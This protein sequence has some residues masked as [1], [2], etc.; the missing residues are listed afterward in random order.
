MCRHK[1]TETMA[2]RRMQS[3][4]LP[5][6]G[7]F[8]FLF[9]CRF[10]E[11]EINVLAKSVENL[12]T[13]FCRIYVESFRRLKRSIRNYRMINVCACMRCGGAAANTFKSRK[14]SPLLNFVPCNDRPM[15]I[16][17]GISFNS[18]HSRLDLSKW[19]KLGMCQ[20]FKISF[21]LN[22]CNVCKNFAVIHF[23]VR[24][25][26]PL[27]AESRRIIWV[28]SGNSLVRKGCARFLSRYEVYHE[29]LSVRCQAEWTQSYIKVNGP[30]WASLGANDFFISFTLI[31]H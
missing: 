21:Q 13:A 14:L 28:D 18:T 16:N 10:L 31:G 26:N 7:V 11:R 20:V 22:G 15:S 17:Y 1:F 24:R 2:R 23:S 19:K 4:R 29:N 6:S 3:K 12:E 9:R 8:F 30:R 25:I 5:T 27:G